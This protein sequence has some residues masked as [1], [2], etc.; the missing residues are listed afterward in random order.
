MP[1]RDRQNALKAQAQRDSSLRRCIAAIDVERSAWLLPPNKR[2]AM[3]TNK[4]PSW[5]TSKGSSS[6]RGYGYAWQKAR[7]DFLQS[8]PLC[9]MCLAMKPSRVKEAQVVD[10]IIPHKGDQG[11]FWD[12]GNWQALCKMHHD[13]DKAEIEGR[14]AA[15]AKFNENGRVV[16]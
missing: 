10:H 6:D 15:K 7:L 2:R 9:V 12:R 16:W 5:R 11:L 13:T 4:Q 3:A 14:H 8:N 1:V